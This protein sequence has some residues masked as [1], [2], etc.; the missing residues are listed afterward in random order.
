M[1][2]RAEEL[3]D[4]KILRDSLEEQ[5]HMPAALVERAD[6]RCRQ[7]EVV[8]EEHPCLA[9]F[10]VLEAD[11]SH[12]RRVMLTAVGAER[13]GLVADNACCS[14]GCRRVDMPGVEIQVGACDEEG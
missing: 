8:G 4:T 6:G 9:G 1:L 11:A 3:L 12:V 5:L 7:R 13:D 10:G 2:R 14:V